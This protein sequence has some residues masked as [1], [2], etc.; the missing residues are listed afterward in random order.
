VHGVYNLHARNGELLFFNIRA[1]ETG[2]LYRA[3]GFPRNHYGTL[4]GKRALHPAALF[5]GEAFNFLRSKNI[6]TIVT[7]EGTAE[8]YAL[9][10]YLRS[11]GKMSGYQIRIVPLTTMPEMAYSRSSR[12]E[13]L[14]GL[15]AAGE[16]INLM[17]RNAP[18]EGAVLLM[19]HAG[20]D[21]V[22]VVAAAYE[23]WRNIGNENR[24]TL[25]QKVMDRYLVSD[26]L[27]KR[28][29]EARKFSGEPYLC[30]DGEEAYVCSEFLEGLRPDLER[31]AQIN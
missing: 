7:L 6:R 26:V 23:L 25:W 15:R 20:K 3:S 13:Q 29:K 16:F 14:F 5:H 17:K 22:G 9:Q 21:A 8:F 19:G 28:D 31:I 27:I 10:G 18:Q 4:D 24:D 2:K 1:I 11:W 12:T 30:K